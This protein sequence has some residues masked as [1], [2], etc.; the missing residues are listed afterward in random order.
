MTTRVFC[1]CHHGDL[2]ESLRILFEDRLGYELYRPVGLEWFH[3]GYWQVVP[4]EDTAR[5]YLLPTNDPF[6]REVFDHNH[7]GRTHRCIRLDDF[8]SDPTDIVISS[9][10]QH[11]PR[12]ERLIRE[13]GG[14]SKH[15]FQVG[16]HGWPAPPGCK[17]ILN[18]TLN[19]YDPGI[20]QVRYHQEFSLDE[21][22]F[23]PCTNPKVITNLVHLQQHHYKHIWDV[24][25]EILEPEGWEFRD[26]GAGNELGPAENPAQAIKD[27]GFIWQM[28]KG[29]TEGYGFN[30]HNAIAC[31]RPVITCFSDYKDRI[32]GCL[33]ANSVSAVDATG[34]N[35]HEIA[36]FLRN[37]LKDNWHDEMCRYAHKMFLSTVDFDKEEAE[38]REFLGRL[39]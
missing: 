14:K 26:Y 31:G 29:Y 24:L 9:M 13:T 34:L 38:I 10:P 6:V 39:Q 17:N 35:G 21:F 18:S 15:I 30:L 4:A 19:R 8:R 3:E 36:E 16:N 12:F 37:M 20:N 7:G 22:N 11:F 28:K 1:D 5:Q 27:S 2:Y 23:V 25:R 33:L 32:G